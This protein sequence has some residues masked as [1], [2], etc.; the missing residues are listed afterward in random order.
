V[1]APIPV[2]SETII[3][4]IPAD[5]L[6]QRP[7]IRRAER[8]L[9]A[10]TAQIGVATADLYPSFGLSGVLQLEAVD[11][12]D[13]GNSSSITWGLGAGFR[14]NIFAG[15][16]IRNRI[17]VEEARTAQALVR[18]EQTVLFA[19]EEVEDAM[20][21]YK[22]ESERRDRLFDSVDAS[23]RS[24]DLVLTQYKAGLT[25]FQNVLDTERSLFNREDDLAESEGFVAGSL[26]ALYRS[27]GGGWD[28]D[29]PSP[30][31]TQAP[32][33]EPE[34]L[35]QADAAAGGTQ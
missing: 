31:L 4:G 26:V 29:A 3:V 13:L 23:R 19:L 15:G 20:V 25:D 8:Q 30:D 2:P 32:A 10:Q 22:K 27:L 12:S 11:F 1:V 14:W 5:L 16:R 21:T 18:Y 6:R 24:L 34:E 35:A 28:P 9:A 17:R 33:D 7:D